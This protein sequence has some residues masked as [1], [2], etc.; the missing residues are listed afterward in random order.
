MQRN[1]DFRPD[2]F[3]CEIPTFLTITVLSFPILTKSDT[4]HQ[5]FTDAKAHSAW[6]HSFQHFHSF[7]KCAVIQTVLIDCDQTVTR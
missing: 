5:G 4:Y 6:G 1:R 7:S 2:E 3:V